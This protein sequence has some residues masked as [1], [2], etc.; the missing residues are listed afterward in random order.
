MAPTVWVTA[1]P[2]SVASVAD[3]RAIFSV[4]AA[5]SE[6]CLIVAV[7]SSMDEDASSTDAAC[8]VVPWDSCWAPEE[9]SWLPDATLSDAPFTS[10]TTDLSLSTMFFM[11]VKQLAGLVLG[12]HLDVHHQIAV[13]KL[14]ADI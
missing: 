14:V 9:S 1:V 4:C 10:P 8:S 11:A 7:I 13:G 6:F 12:L 2:L 3:L 5:L